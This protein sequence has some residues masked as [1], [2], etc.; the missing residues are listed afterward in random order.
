MHQV[1]I[2]QK[3]RAVKVTIT[4]FMYGVE[5]HR[6]TS[7]GSADVS[8]E[9]QV[10]HHVPAIPWWCI[11]TRGALA[12]HSR[13]IT[14]RAVSNPLL[15]ASNSVPIL[16][17]VML[18]CMALTA[19]ST[20][21]AAYSGLRAHLTLRTVKVTT[22]ESTVHWTS[23]LVAILILIWRQI[24]APPGKPVPVVSTKKQRHP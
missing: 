20:T 4:E 11:L 16:L 3:R 8:T 10:H 22:L 1:V 6:P 7:P 21:T 5:L 15:C 9:L 14:A 13:T 2:I 24:N 12:L 18:F 19:E 17:G 23:V